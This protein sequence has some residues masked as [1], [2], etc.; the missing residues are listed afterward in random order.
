MLKVPQTIRHI[1]LNTLNSFSSVSISGVWKDGIVSGGIYEEESNIKGYAG[2]EKEGHSN[3]PQVK[4][5]KDVS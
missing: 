4:E 1:F 3:D 5:A 2:S